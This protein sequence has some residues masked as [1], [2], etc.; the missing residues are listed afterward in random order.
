MTIKENKNKAYLVPG[1]DFEISDN[2]TSTL[3]YRGKGNVLMNLFQVA[4]VKEQLVALARNE[5][6]QEN[7]I[8]AYFADTEKSINSQLANPISRQKIMNNIAARTA[9]VTGEDKMNN[10]VVTI[11][12]ENIETEQQEV[13]PSK[14][15]VDNENRVCAV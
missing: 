3:T 9:S 6:L 10:L 11:S 14:L 15:V 13:E 2:N 4:S 1:R 8:N 5:E 7:L 12:F